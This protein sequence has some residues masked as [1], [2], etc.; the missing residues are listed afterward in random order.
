MHD[1]TTF[2]SISSKNVVNKAMPTPVAMQTKMNTFFI[3]PSN[4]THKF[5]QFT[6]FIQVTMKFK[7]Y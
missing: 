7:T 3:F 5:Y 1:I 2:T 4:K 6:N